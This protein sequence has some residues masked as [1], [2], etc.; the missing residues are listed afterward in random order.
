[1]QRGFTKGT[2]QIE[3]ARERAFPETGKR[4]VCPS[5]PN[6]NWAKWWKQLLFWVAVRLKLRYS[7]PKMTRFILIYGDE[8]SCRSWFYAKV[9]NLNASNVC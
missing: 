1:M 7:G 3:I 2:C 8:T 6:I 9:A 5:L 4:F